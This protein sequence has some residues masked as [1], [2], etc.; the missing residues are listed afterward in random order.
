MRI[1]IDQPPTL[2]RA[3]LL[4]VVAV[5]VGLW[6]T[7]PSRV[8]AFALDG[9]HFHIGQTLIFNDFTT[10]AAGS[11]VQGSEVSPL[12]LTGG[13]GAVLHLGGNHYW[14]PQLSLLSQEYAALRNPAYKGKVVPTQIETGRVVAD[15]AGTLIAALSLPYSYRF[16]P[17]ATPTWSFDLGISPAFVFRIPVVPIDGTSTEPIAA[18]FFSN[19]RFLMAELSAGAYYRFSERL[20]LGLTVRWFLPVYN[21]WAQTVPTSFLD[22]MLLFMGAS[23]RTV[24]RR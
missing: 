4:V 23:V 6:I 3:V 20:D 19:A 22:E 1:R 13:G 10:D 12:R 24:R 14:S 7:T 5:A 15:I 8:N 17:A 16:R 11:P 2:R 9:F 21:G 18:Y